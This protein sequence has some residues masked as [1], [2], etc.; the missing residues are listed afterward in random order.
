ML[1]AMSLLVALTTAGAQEPRIEMKTYQ[2]VFLR[3][4]P[5]SG[6]GSE[7]AEK[8]Q[9]AHL[10]F[11]AE[12]NR[13]RVNLLYGP[14]RDDGDLRGIAVLDVPD[15]DAATKVF[16]NDPHVWAGHLVV[17][18]KGWYAPAGFFNPPL[19]PPTPENLVLG[20]LMRGGKRSQSAAEAEDIQKKHLA[21]MSELRSQGKLPVAGPFSEDSDWRGVVI[22]RVQTIDQAQQ[23]AQGDPA[24]RAGRLRIDARPWLTWKGILR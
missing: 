14:F 10:A 13:K 21:Y 6:G 9:A 7:N 2:M 11:L 3:R 4:G 1:A 17:D 16:A 5:A 15:A 8:V 18:V 22:Y 20:F 23:L 12:L 24:V 19:E